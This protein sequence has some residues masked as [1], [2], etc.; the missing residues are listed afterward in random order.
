MKASIGFSG[1]SKKAGSNRASESPGYREKGVLPGF[2]V[3]CMLG[4]LARWLRILGFDTLYFRKSSDQELQA[5]QKKSGRILLTRDT[6]LARSGTEGPALL[7][8][9]DKWDAQ[10]RQ[11]LDAFSLK[12]SRERLFTRCT[13][14][15]HLLTVMSRNEVSGKIPD[16]VSSTQHAFRGCEAC[17]KIY[18]SGTHRNHVLRVLER[19]TAGEVRA[20]E[21]R[22]TEDRGQDS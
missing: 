10:I 19:L 17:G 20:R 16:F 1:L 15:N 4:R 9:E 12:V 6:G 3:D 2:L 13:L 8:E 11:V 5:C 14:C 18:W 21:S 7:I 22:K